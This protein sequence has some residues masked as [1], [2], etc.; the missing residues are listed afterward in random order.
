MIIQDHE[1][2]CDLGDG[3]TV[4][5]SKEY[6]RFTTDSILLSD[7]SRAKRGDRCVDLGSGQ[8]ILSILLFKKYQVASVDAVEIQPELCEYIK[9][10]A[11]INQLD[12]LFI[13]NCDMRYHSLN[14]GKYDVV[15]CNPPYAKDGTGFANKK[16]SIVIAKQEIAIQ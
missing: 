9:K 5:Q 4:L 6:F 13:H 2:L 8:G 11:H 3:Y 14:K 12:S 10:N 16:S 15:I 1:Q 7:F